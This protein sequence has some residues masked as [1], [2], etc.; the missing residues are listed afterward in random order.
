VISARLLV[1][2]KRARDSLVRGRAVL[3]SA[4][5][6]LLLAQVAAGCGSSENGMASKS[7]TQILAAS[8]SAVQK[9]SSVHVLA[10]TKVTHGGSLSLD[11][12]LSKDQ[13]RAHISFLGLGFEVIRK[14]NT[15]YLKG[16]RAFNARL[17]ATMGV[18]VQSGVWLKGTTRS[19]GQVGSF[20]DIERELPLI[21]SGSG[22]VSKGAHVKINGQ[23]A[24]TLTEVRKLYTGTLYV[25]TTGEPYPLQLRK[26]GRETGQTTFTGW[27]DPVSVTAP[28]KTVEI[29]QLQHIKKGH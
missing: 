28:A 18:K 14:G 26:S 19:L 8:R 10:S 17:E 4:V 13:A 1:A 16:N 24:I 15:L 21:L 9:A 23:P 20:T 25:A 27:N 11:A 6:A 12:T 3:L 22:P 2:C 5:V 7:A 29:S